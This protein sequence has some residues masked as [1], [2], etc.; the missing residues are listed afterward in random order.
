MLICSVI[1]GSAHLSRTLEQA[2]P[3]PSFIRYRLLSLHAVDMGFTHAACSSSA[4][5]GAVSGQALGNLLSQ[6]LPARLVPSSVISCYPVA[7]YWACHHGL[8]PRVL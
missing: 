6:A 5:D 1:A 8:C 3:G 2:R 7:T 4:T